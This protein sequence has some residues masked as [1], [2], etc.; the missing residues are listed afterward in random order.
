MKDKIKL[1]VTDLDGTLLNAQKQFPA[2]I[3]P[4]IDELERRGVTFALASGRGFRT[5]SD[6]F[7][8]GAWRIPLLCENGSVLTRAGEVVS[9]VSMSDEEVELVLS[10]GEEISPFYPVVCGVNNVYIQDD[11]PDFI[12]LLDKFSPHKLI[13]DDVRE[14][15]KLETV[16]KIAFWEPHD[17]EAYAYDHMR[18]LG[19]SF[20]YML[21]GDNWL[22]VLKP[23]GDKGACLQR[24]QNLLGVT[25]E[26]TMCFGDFPND[27][28]LMQNCE[29]SFAM[30][31]A[32]PYIKDICKYETELTNE[33]DGVIETILERLGIDAKLLVTA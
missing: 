7:P 19:D 15:A 8:E 13:V 20:N 17:V 10:K 33:E 29:Y 26:E 21:S 32:H 28:G 23:G 6:A 14:A 25:P 24:L 30:K 31:N 16:I 12:E 5:L 11:V 2:R 4:L 9:I 18:A 22:D 3:I 27:E 1:I